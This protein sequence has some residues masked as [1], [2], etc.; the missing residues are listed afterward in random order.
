VGV[1]QISPSSIE[2]QVLDG[3]YVPDVMLNGFFF[4]L[5][6]LSAAIETKILW[7]ISL[8]GRNYTAFIL[9]SDVELTSRRLTCA[10]VEKM[11]C[12]HCSVFLPLIWIGR[13]MKLDIN[14]AGNY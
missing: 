6:V 2:K 3:W 1:R 9:A 11:C 8:T 12:F 10:A 4:G 5:S 13:R 14:L 7:L